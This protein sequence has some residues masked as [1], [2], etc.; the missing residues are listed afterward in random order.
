[1]HRTAS[2]CLKRNEWK[3]WRETATNWWRNK[4]LFI[5]HC[6]DWLVKRI[7]IFD[8]FCI[9]KIF[10]LLWA[11]RTNIQH[12]ASEDEADGK[13]LAIYALS[14]IAKYIYVCSV[15]GIEIFSSVFFFV[16]KW[17]PLR[18]WKIFESQ[19]YGLIWWMLMNTKQTALYGS[20]VA[21]VNVNANLFHRIRSNW[22]LGVREFYIVHL[23]YFPLFFLS[24]WAFQSLTAVRLSRD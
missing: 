20:K 14:Q 1:M 18:R 21:D 11:P 10:V 7:K 9:V 6:G 19:V 13:M 2:V 16:E 23:L 12:S 3:I 5:K 24:I 17:Q 4:T 15:Y 8:I 22:P